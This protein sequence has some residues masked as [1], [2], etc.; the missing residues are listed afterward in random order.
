M[1]IT[2]HSPIGDLRDFALDMA[3]VE[4]NRGRNVATPA[5]NPAASGL[6]FAIN[7]GTIVTGS[8][9]VVTVDRRV[10]VPLS[11]NAENYVSRDASGVV[12]VQADAFADAVPLWV[13]TTAN[14]HITAIRDCRAA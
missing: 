12:S 13:I 14:G 9:A 11:D 10:F 7:G 2:I 4:R 3:E 6:S 5:T 1:S 8:G